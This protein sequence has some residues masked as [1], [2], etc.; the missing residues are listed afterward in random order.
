LKHADDVGH[1][2]GSGDGDIGVA[3][4]EIF[5][6]G[7]AGIID[8]SVQLGEPLPDARSEGIDGVLM[9]DVEL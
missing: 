7:D 5:P 1:D 6:S 8:K 4:G 2:D 3:S 9:L